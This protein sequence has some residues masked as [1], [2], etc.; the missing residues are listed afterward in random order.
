MAAPV[1]MEYRIEGNNFMVAGTASNNIKN[2]LKMLG[3]QSDVCRRAAVIAYEAEINLVIHANGGMLKAVISEDRLEITAEDEGPGIPDIE[4][5]MTEGYTTASNQAR[6]MGFGAG[7]G[8]PNIK[9]NS[10]I[11][12]IESTLGKGTVL[13]STVFFNK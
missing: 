9:R 1:C 11:F 8:L 6:E 13:R 4:Q 5:A 12:E 2:T 3:I 7:M 10:D